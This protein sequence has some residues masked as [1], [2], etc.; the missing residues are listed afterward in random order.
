MRPF[1]LTQAL[2]QA[3]EA[4]APSLERDLRVDVCI[5]GG[6][7][8]GLWTAIML[9]QQAP[10]LRV[11][12]IE[13]DLCGAGASGRNGGCVLGWASKY[14]TLHRLFGEEEARRLVVESERSVA[15]IGDFCRE[16]GI[17]AEFRHDGTLF[18][19]TNGAQQADIAPLMN[20]LAE[21][22]IGSFASLEAAEVQRRSGSARHRQGW[23]SPRAATVQPA[24]L[25]RGLRRVA[26]ELGV[27]LFERTPMQALERGRPARVVTPRGSL[28]ADKVVLATNAWTAR[29]LPEYRRTIAIVSS[30]M[31][32]TE[33]APEALAE[34]GLV[35][36]VSVLDSRTFVHYYRTTPQGRLMLGKGG[37]TF[38]F[39]G[40][41]HGVFDRPSRYRAALRQSLTEFFPRLAEVPLAASWTGP[42]D[43]SVTGLPFFGALPGHANIVYGFGYSGNGVG[44]TRM[45]AKLLT[46]LVL[47][48]NNLWRRS[49]LARGPLGQFPPEPVR[50]LG[51]LMVRNAI[52]RK[53]RHED[54]ERLPRPWDRWLAN[55]A[56]AAG[57]SDK[58][59]S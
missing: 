30:D 25:A 43:R 8:T 22:G 23:F 11:A 13:A 35:D 46:A 53:E 29:L 57:K 51:S 44:P 26:R 18:T 27:E 21:R 16:H 36:G 52:R 49:P 9:R 2:E 47:E 48:Q 54:L 38:A 17:E 24:K 28:I 40:H 12:L 15:E 59:A 33:P 56:A 37:N 7:Y 10:G 20:G 55:F 3:P 5:V 4:P 58:L 31:V 50:Y 32:I 1:W 14:P 19:A 6:G 45:G 41:V 42:S 39:G 34:T